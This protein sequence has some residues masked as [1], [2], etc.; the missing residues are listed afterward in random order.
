[1]SAPRPVP[2]KTKSPITPTKL[3]ENVEG[4]V[5]VDRRLWTE[6]LNGDVVKYVDIDGKF[7]AGGTVQAVFEKDGIKYISIH[8]NIRTQRKLFPF[9]ARMDRIAVIYK[10]PSVD[11]IMLSVEIIKLRKEIEALVGKKLPPI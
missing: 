7:H 8:P 9:S 6:L 11:Y 1:M 4:M 10:R 3:A 5:I 2:L